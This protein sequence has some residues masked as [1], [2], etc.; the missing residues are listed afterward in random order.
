[1]G[2]AQSISDE[3]PSIQKF[4]KRNTDRLSVYEKINIYYIIILPL[5]FVLIGFLNNIITTLE[6]VNII[7]DVKICL[8][9]CTSM[10]LCLVP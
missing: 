7:H 3:N 6:F 10:N 8:Y 4:S 2:K 1:M 9:K 5:G